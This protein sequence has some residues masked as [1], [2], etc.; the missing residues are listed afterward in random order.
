ML[1]LSGVAPLAA[2]EEE[3]DPPEI[4]IGE[5][6]FLETRFAQAFK[7]YLDAGGAVSAPIEQG[8]PALES[9]ATTGDPLPGPFAGQTF[10]CRNCHMVDELADAEGGGM[11]TYADYARRS[12]VPVREDGLT[13]T[14]R[15]SPSLVNASQ[16]RSGGLI[17]HL[18]GEF[19]SMEDLVRG[20]LAGRNFGWLPG[21]GGQAPGHVA[22]IVREDD[23]AGEL[24][25]EFG[26]LPYAVTLT[27]TDPSIPAEL[28]LPEEFR[29]DVAT[30]SDAEI[31]DAVAKLIA[32]YTVDLSFATDDS[33]SFSRS[34]YDVF[35]AANELPRKPRVGE[36]PLDYS[37]RLLTLIRNAENAGSLQLIYSDP[38]THVGSFAFHDQGFV[39]G[40]RELLGLKIFFSE[41]AGAAATASETTAGGRG[42]CIRCHSA[43][44]FTDFRFHNT[45]VTQVEYD[46]IHG[47]GAFSALVIPGFEA[48]QGEPD[49]YLPAND[50]RPGAMQPFFRTPSADH[51]GWVDLGAWNM[52]ANPDVARPQGKM[53]RTFCEPELLEAR[54]EL[55]RRSRARLDVLLNS[56]MMREDRDFSPCK[57]EEL[58]PRTVAAFKTAGLRDLGH[59]NPYMHNG[60]FDSLSSVLVHYMNAAE[61]TH[62][63]RLRN[64]ARDLG[65]VAITKIDVD[66]LVAFLRALN[67]DYN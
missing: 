5:R 6:L 14:V 12:L 1:L 44:L 33:G 21:E 16:A 65:A 4:T 9:L 2:Q 36:S 40:N 48:R 50:E 11:R 51:P 10:N 64:P 29:V 38:E 37:R 61:L 3:A 60:A 57:R 34:P 56:Y 26:A 53:W 35:L 59:S 24:A 54:P 28:V 43:P 46:S 23:G 13:T 25:V 63:N 55:A 32:A 8:D 20:T 58:L 22:R 67:E 19:S 52:F 45:G 62:A 41:P 30:A 47:D 27:G 39:F 15:N 31:F 49:R 42:A 18:D 7:A 17:F 66:P